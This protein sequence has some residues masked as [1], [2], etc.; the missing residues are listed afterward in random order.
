[1]LFDS[2]D[3]R[4]PDDDLAWLARTVQSQPFEIAYS[5]VNWARLTV[6]R[7]LIAQ[8]FDTEE[9]RACLPLL[10]EVRVHYCDDYP[11]DG[12][13]A[14]Q[15]WLMAGWLAARL[16]WTVA[17]PLEQKDAVTRV[18][19]QGG[20]GQSIALVLERDSCTFEGYRGLT[21]VDLIAWQPRAMRFR[22]E[23]L[24]EQGAARTVMALADAPTVDRAV[25]MDENSDAVLISREFESPGRDRSYEEA[26]HASVSLAGVAAHV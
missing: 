26:L 19:L 3:F 15:A 13:V 16:G 17:G 20:D 2:A 8:F 24:G 7:G 18:A 1:M 10:Q 14:S 6:W 25:K 22:V 23:H 4:E 11:R 21:S 5:D 12:R 9:A